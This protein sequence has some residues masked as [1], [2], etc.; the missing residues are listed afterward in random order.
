MT[1]TVRYSTTAVRDAVL[2]SPMGDGMEMSYAR[3]DG[4]LGKLHGADAV[5]G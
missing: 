3:L 1:M 5:K 4:L 2:G